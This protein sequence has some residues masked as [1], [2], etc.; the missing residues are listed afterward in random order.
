M[1][2]T[3]HR[4]THQIGGCV[5]ELR[6]KTTRILI[7]LGSPLPGPEG[8]VPE[9]NLVLP[10][11]TAPG[12][13]CHGVFFTHTHSDHMGQIGQ[14][15]PTVPLWMT[16]TARDVALAL[17]RRLERVPGTDNV[18]VSAALERVNTFRPGVPV[19]VGDIRITPFLVDHSAFDAYMFLVE[20]DGVKLLHTGDFREHG[21]RG[22]ALIPVLER[23]VGQVDWLICEGTNLSRPQRSAMTE[24]ELGKEARRLMEMHR[25]V[26]VLC[27]STNIDRIAVLSHCAPPRRPV[28]CDGYQKEVLDIVESRSGGRSSLYR[29]DRVIPYWEGNTKLR[30]WMEDQGFVMFVRANDRFRQWMEPYREDCIVLYSLWDGYLEGPN[31]NP[32]GGVSGGLPGPQAPHQRPR[33]GGN[34][35]G[36]L[37]YRIPQPGAHPHPRGKPRGLPRPGTGDPGSLPGG[38]TG[39]FPLM[40]DTKRYVRMDGLNRYLGCLLGGAAGDA[41]GYPV[42]F[43]SRNEILARCGPSGITDYALQDWGSPDFR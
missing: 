40:Q 16:E 18:R 15:L 25:H 36:G 11:V 2:V 30:Q 6:T 33:W 8:A 23:Y 13:P 31:A 39:P 3:V 4:G 27:S 22:K 35:A 42:E 28:V 12:E 43:N 24:F 19:V 29:F 37:P 41:L 9:E 17:S 14:I 32:A 7:D 21:P 5:T 26:F 20:A 1:T 38:R 10:G 34:A